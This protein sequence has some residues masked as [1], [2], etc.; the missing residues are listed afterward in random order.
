MNILFKNCK[1]NLL[2]YAKKSIIE[3]VKIYLNVRKNEGGNDLA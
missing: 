2:F 1:K 3:K